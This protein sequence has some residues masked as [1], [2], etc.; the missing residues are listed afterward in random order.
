MLRMLEESSR[1]V[2]R[3]KAD[4]Q[5]GKQNQKT[6]NARPRAQCLEQTIDQMSGKLVKES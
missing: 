6:G 1:K 3:R 4:N 5:D 2:H